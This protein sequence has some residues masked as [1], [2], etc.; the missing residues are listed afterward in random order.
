MNCGLSSL[1]AHWAASVLGVHCPGQGAFPQGEEKGTW[2]VS[3]VP[4]GWVIPGVCPLQCLTRSRLCRRG[5]ADP[6]RQPLG[7]D[8]GLG[9][10]EG[11]PGPPPLELGCGPEVQKRRSWSLPAAL[12]WDVGGGA[13]RKSWSL[14]LELGRWPWRCRRGS[15]VP[16]LPLGQGLAEAPGLL[17][18][19]LCLRSPLPPHVLKH[20]F[21]FSVLEHVTQQ[22][23]SCLVKH[24]RP[25]AG[26]LGLSHLG[27]PSAWHGQELEQG[28][29]ACSLNE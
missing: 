29:S 11:S 24:R 10:E 3:L 19:Q 18:L 13:E 6:C 14:P 8:A 5:S 23:E 26:G 21:C 16:P 28:P 17:C 4:R 27:P 2:P 1:Q 25:F 15:L 20:L 22:F 9:A 7:W 12:G